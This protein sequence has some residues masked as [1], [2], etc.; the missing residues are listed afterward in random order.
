MKAEAYCCQFKFCF[1]CCCLPYRFQ[2]RCCYYS[3]GDDDG[4]SPKP[5]KKS[6]ISVNDDVKA[7]YS[8]TA[9]MK[10]KFPMPQEKKSKAKNQECSISIKMNC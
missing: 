8:A 5:N 9:K 4:E 1:L 7:C 2:R 3:C 6:R 10:L